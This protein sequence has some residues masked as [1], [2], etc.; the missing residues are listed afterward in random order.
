VI[1]ETYIPNLSVVPCGSLIPNPSEVLGS[2]QMK[3]FLEQARRRFEIIIFDSPPL[4]A[5]TDSVVIGTQ[6]D[7]VVL[8][9][10]CGVT[11]RDVAKLKLEMFRNV[12]AKILGAVL[13]GAEANLAHDG[14]SYY[15]Y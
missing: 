10:R 3:R 1:R 4:N 11:N 8:V 2:L 14:Y 15:H 9:V 12:P 5:A 7:G 6:V 13:N